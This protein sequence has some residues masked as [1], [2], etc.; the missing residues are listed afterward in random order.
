VGFL[1]RL[2]P[3]ALQERG[4]VRADYTRREPT[5]PGLAHTQLVEAFS[6]QTA[7]IMGRMEIK[8]PGPQSKWVLMSSREGQDIQT[9]VKSPKG[10][11]DVKVVYPS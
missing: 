8:R 3:D 9:N 7:S 6:A 2:P 1:T 11:S 5:I 4:K 10:S